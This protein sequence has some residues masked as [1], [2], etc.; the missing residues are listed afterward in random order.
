MPDTDTHTSPPLTEQVADKA[1]QQTQQVKEQ[2]QQAVQQGQQKVNQV[3]ELGRTQFRGALTGQKE[4]VATGLGDVAQMLTQSA[5]TLRDQGQPGGSVL[6]DS[7][8]QRITK[9]SET[10]HQKEIEEI[11]SDTEDFARRQP[12]VFLTIATLLG[13]LLARFLKSSGQGTSAS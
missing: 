9:L 4:R 13:I 3:W 5:A 1:K 11:L 10:V 7:L 2:A 6:A 8:A 12:A